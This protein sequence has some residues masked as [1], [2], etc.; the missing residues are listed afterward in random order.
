ML[1]QKICDCSVCEFP[2]NSANPI[3][4]YLNINSIRNKFNHLQELIKGNIDV[5]MIA[6]AK[7]DASF[8][9][10]III[11]SKSGGILVYVKSSVSFNPAGNYMFKVNNRNTR[12]RCETC[13]KLTIKTPER[14]H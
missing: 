6:E 5:V 2:A 13:S 12:T 11:K 14:R 3:F 9:T 1:L 7:I 8:T 10:A 4:A